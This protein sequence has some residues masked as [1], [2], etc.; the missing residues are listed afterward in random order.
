MIQCSLIRILFVNQHGAALPLDEV[1]DIAYAPGLLPRRRAQVAQNLINV[2]AVRLVKRHSYDK[3]QHIRAFFLCG[4]RFSY[5][6]SA[7][8]NSGSI[9]VWSRSGPVET[10]PIFAPD[11]FSTNF[12]YSCASFGSLSNSVIPS[13][14][15]FHPFSFV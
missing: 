14:E 1:G 8:S 4:W 15:A 2:G 11:S 10:I 13:V 12:K 3:T 6:F 7:W 5:A 9:M